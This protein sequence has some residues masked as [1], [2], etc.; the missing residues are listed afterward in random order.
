MELSGWDKYP[1]INAQV[2][3]PLTPED[4][5]RC[6]GGN[7]HNPLIA[8]GLGRSYGDS[9]LAP[10]VISTRYLD[11]LL[12]FDEYSGV[13]TCS[14]GVSFAHILSVFVPKG[15]FPPVTPG[16]KFVTVGGAI[17]SD[18]HG[19]NHHLEGSFTDHV[20]CLKIATVSDG[21]VEC[22]RERHPELFQATCGGMGLTGVILEATFGLK[23]IKS[24]YIDETTLK[25]KTLEEALDLF[26]IHHNAS[27]SVAWLD[28][29]SSGRSLG[30]SVVML[31]EHSAQGGLTPGKS[32]TLIVPVDMP[33]FVL[34]RYTIRAFNALYYNLL[35]KKRTERR[36]HYE[37]FFY[38]L[39]GI[40]HWNRLYG[41]NGFTQYQFVIPK[42]ASLE[43]LTT[44]LE[45]IAA[46]KHASA[47]AVLK[48][49]GKNNINHLSFP[50]E[51]CT[52]ALDFKLDTGLFELLNELD[53]IVLDYGGRVYLTKDVRMSAEMFKRSYPRWQS[54]MKVRKA[55]GADRVFH[56]L[57][58]QRLG[59]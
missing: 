37:P 34:N 32:L 40:R 36:I 10:H 4:V 20:S 26:A 8:R 48:A 46:S 50:M 54:F 33:S 43:G 28:C 3:H 16:T 14:A 24:A 19:K 17:A 51:G 21:I 55:Y 31:G 49:F 25:A 30:R 22:S 23:P 44:V 47:L 18:I 2:F 38:P 45:R 11:H 35:R 52:L 1:T 56:S 39:D 27:Y 29:S 41:K 15:W 42:Q 12:S 7:P 9:S 5:L 59:L 6:I 57:Q 13:L 58:S 53:S